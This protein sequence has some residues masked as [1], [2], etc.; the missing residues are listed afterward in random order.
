MGSSSPGRWP[1]PLPAHCAP[2][3]LGYQPRFP[4]SR[5][6]SA[7]WLGGAYTRVC[8]YTYTTHTNTYEIQMQILFLSLCKIHTLYVYGYTK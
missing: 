1:D 8:V 4:G 6:V 5:L 2:S 3:S 7:L